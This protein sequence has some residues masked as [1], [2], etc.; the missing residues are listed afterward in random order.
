MTAALDRVA[1]RL[2]EDAR[3][4]LTKY[5]RDHGDRRVLVALALVAEEQR[6]LYAFLVEL[7]GLGMLSAGI[8]S[9]LGCSPGTIERRVR[10]LLADGFGRRISEALAETKARNAAARRAS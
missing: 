10:G 3:R 1:A 2:P 7:V 5:R 6:L 9:A 8:A 4:V